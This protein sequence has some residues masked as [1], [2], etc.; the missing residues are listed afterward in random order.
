M[1]PPQPAL[2]GKQKAEIR[3]KSPFGCLVRIAERSCPVSYVTLAL[4]FEGVNQTHVEV[5][6]KELV[7]TARKK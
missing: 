2:F 1:Q 7:S 5:I 3:L 4:S 6:E